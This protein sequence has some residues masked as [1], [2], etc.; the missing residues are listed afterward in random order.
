MSDEESTN[1]IEASDP[2]QVPE[3]TEEEVKSLQARALETEREPLLDEG[4]VT[5][6]PVCDGP[7]VTTNDLKKAIPTPRG[8]TLVTRLPGARCAQC[9]ASQLDPAALAL[10]LEHSGEE[11]ISDYETTVTQA[12]GQALG[13]YFRKDLTRVLGL[14]GREHLRWTVLD[15]DHALV[16]IQREAE[17]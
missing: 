14:T 3:I 11:I 17:A 10:I 9:N 6:C 2:D 8:L 13:T 16:E 7:M 5:Q 15:K 4:Q 12:S 1:D